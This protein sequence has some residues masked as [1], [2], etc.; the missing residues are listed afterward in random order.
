MP[1]ILFDAP[2]RI[3]PDS[4]VPLFLIIRDAHRYPVEIEEV[5]V[6]IVSED[7]TEGPRTFAR[8]DYG[9]L[10][11][12]ARFPYWGLPVKEPLW[13]DSFTFMPDREGTAVIHPAVVF[14]MNGKRFSIEVDTYP[15]T[16]RRPLTVRVSPTKLPSAEGWYH[17][18]IH[19]H[20]EYTA[21]QVEFGA[22]LEMTAF[23][24]LCAGMDWIA[25]TDHSYDLDDPP[26]DDSARNCAFHKSWRP[27]NAADPGLGKWRMMRAKTALINESSDAGSQT[28]ALHAS[29][30]RFISV[31]PGEE[32]TCRTRRGRNCH[33]LALGSD[34]FIP[35][36]GDGGERGFST[37][38]ER[39][40]GEAAAECIEWGGIACAAHPLERIPIPERLILG[41]GEWERADMETPGVAALQIHNG[42]RDRGFKRGMAAWIG[43]LLGGRRMFAFGG[44]DSHGDM[45][46][47]RTI[48]VPFLTVRESAHHVLGA[49][50][51]AVFAR[52]G[53]WKDIL[54]ALMAGRAQ[55]T[56]GPFID[57]VVGSSG[58]EAR[59]G[60]TVSAD[61]HHIRAVCTSTPEFGKLKQ[62]R[63]LAGRKGESSE[64][65]LT[66]L[67]PFLKDVYHHEFD[68]TFSLCGLLYVR[69]E[70]ITDMGRLCFT[71]PVWV[72][73]G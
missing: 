21:D 36:S 54:E 63:L 59:P 48:G 6:K 17:G 30:T 7:G 73:K 16:S 31:I 22:P 60:D 55:V 34:K 52:S 13:W 42:V 57:L 25:A 56:E 66:V 43:L 26:E 58:Q 37:A 14:R 23:A 49:V 11:R 53:S 41:R 46:R 47:R 35:G 32:V 8:N 4:P 69:A 18:D 19:C 1:E 65:V 12:A 51:T 45:N 24:A 44:S 10:Q 28:C 67:D 64:R 40:I 39:S 5:T 62:G 61:H 50:R 3:D 68:G 72:E 27:Y 15:G 33:L 2:A 70:C 38:T 20:T 29:G 71:N 9:Y